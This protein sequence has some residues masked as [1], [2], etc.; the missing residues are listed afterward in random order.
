MQ[1]NYEPFRSIRFPQEIIVKRE[2]GGKAE[3]VLHR[4]PQGPP[5]GRRDRGGP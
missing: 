1:V 2:S 4:A 5:R 3:E